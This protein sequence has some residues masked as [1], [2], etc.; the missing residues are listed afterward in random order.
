[1]SRASCCVKD[2]DMSKEIKEIG[3]FQ[4]LSELVDYV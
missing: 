1:M 3:V 4:I 2:C